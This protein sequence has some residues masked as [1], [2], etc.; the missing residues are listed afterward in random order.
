MS[1]R[2]LP[3]WFADTVRHHPDATALELADRAL[4]YRELDRCAAA[5][6]ARIRAAHGDR[7]DRVALLANRSLVAFAGYLAVQRLGAAVVPLNVDHPVR[8]NRLIADTSPFDVLL[9]DPSGGPQ[10]DTGL[11]DTPATVLRLTDDEVFD[12][13]P[14]DLPPSP[15]GPDDVAY[16]LFTSGSTGRPK[17]VP[18]RHRNVDPYLARN[19]ARFAVGPGCR[20]SHTFDLTFDPSVFDLFVTWGAGATLVCPDRTELLNPVTYLVERGIT[21]WFS[22]PSVVTV[23]G[24]LGTLPTGL[25]TS[26]RHSVFI[27]EQLTLKTAAAWREVAPGTVIDNVYGPT[28]LTIACTEYRLPADPAAWPA[29]SND[30]VPIGPVYEFLDHVVVDEAGR[31]APDGELCVRGSQRFDGYVDPADDTGR[32]LRADGDR[33]VPVQGPVEPG[34]YYRTGDRV[35]TEHGELVHLGRMDHQVKVRGY[36]MELGEI[37]TALRRHPGIDDAVVLAV[38]V[39]EDLRLIACHTGTPTPSREL[40]RW[41]RSRLPVHMV[42]RHWHHVP[43]MPLNANGK[44]DRTALR[45]LALDALRLEPTVGA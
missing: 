27:G 28:E 18:I 9:A 17:G 31:P 21:H 15:A 45:D 2:T 19:I 3:Q 44:T 36:R 5:L 14:A 7:L 41:L 37:E 30:T 4:T 12:A 1:A 43:K 13:S 6:A 38:R 8:R 10:L 23:G 35:R 32:F 33:Y 29:T 16:V 20:M 25:A 40:V 24:Q 22:V 39:D 26:V 34:D 11:G 42:P